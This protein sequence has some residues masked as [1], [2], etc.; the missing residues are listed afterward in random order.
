MRQHVPRP[1]QQESGVA[2]QCH[3]NAVLRCRHM[4]RPAARSQVDS[5]KTSHV[6]P[7]FPH[8]DEDAIQ[9]EHTHTVSDDALLQFCLEAQSNCRERGS[10]IHWQ[11]R[12]LDLQ[13]IS[14]QYSVN[15]LLPAVP[16]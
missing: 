16:E 14:S 4:F 10:I 6:H 9:L 8:I 12:E 1:Q 15:D 11:T 7:C 3:L 13:C 2:L 5:I